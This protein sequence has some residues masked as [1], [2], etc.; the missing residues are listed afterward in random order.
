[1]AFDE[2]REKVKDQVVEKWEEVKESSAF[3]SLKEKYDDLTPNAQILI[4]GVGVFF[5]GSLVFM[6]I[7]G[8][9]SEANQR[10]NEF[11]ETKQTIREMLRLKRDIAQAPRIPS[12]PPESALKSQVDRVIESFNLD[13]VQI[14][15]ITVQEFKS[16]PKSDLVPRSV[17]QAGVLVSLKQ[18][19]LNQ[20]V[21]VGFRLQNIN[22][23]AKLTAVDMK[24][25]EENDHYFNVMYT[26]IGYY[27]PEVEGQD[28]GSEER[29]TRPRS[30]RSRPAPR[31]GR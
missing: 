10:I 24:P 17:R 19:N 3:I 13:P 23:A 21:D 12:P 25:S 27:P 16:D 11:E 2:L 14:D 22:S 29:A 6:L 28:E 15:E 31:G 5:A 20:V 7:F 26:L 4:K 8:F 9:F 1:M 30:R 18:L